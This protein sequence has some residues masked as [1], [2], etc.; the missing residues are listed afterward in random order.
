MEF[1]AARKLSNATN[2][3]VLHYENL[4]LI[5]K[6]V[7]SAR[8]RLYVNIPLGRRIFYAFYHTE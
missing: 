5:N 1:Y 4:K 7:A 2:I 8:K 6:N 3:F